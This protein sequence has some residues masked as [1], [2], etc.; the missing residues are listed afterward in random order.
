MLH[1]VPDADLS[2]VLVEFRRVLQPSGFLL[3]GGHA[4]EDSRLK[5]EGYGGHPMNVQVNRRSVAA[6]SGFLCG[7]GFVIDARVMLD[8]HD[9]SPACAIFGRLTVAQKSTPMT[10]P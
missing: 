3:M 7:S 4:G 2:A 1:H 9:A 5:T 6:M 8:P 10:D